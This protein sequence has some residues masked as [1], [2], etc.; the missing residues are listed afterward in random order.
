MHVRSS[1]AV[2]SSEMSVK[3][4]KSKLKNNILNI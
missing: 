1:S 3:L 4:E 2:T